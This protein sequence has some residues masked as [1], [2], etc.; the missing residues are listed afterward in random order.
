MACPCKPLPSPDGFLALSFYQPIEDTAPDTQSLG[1]CPAFPLIIQRRH[2]REP[3]NLGANGIRTAVYCGLGALRAFRQGLPDLTARIRRW[4]FRPTEQVCGNPV[5][6]IDQHRSD[7]FECTS[8]LEKRVDDKPDGAAFIAA[9]ARAASILDN[10]CWIPPVGL[11]CMRHGISL[12]GLFRGVEVGDDLI[13]NGV[14]IGKLIE[15]GRNLVAGNGDEALAIAIDLDADA[16]RDCK[17]TMD[18]PVAAGAE[19]SDALTA[20]RNLNITAATLDQPLR[21]VVKDARFRIAAVV[22]VEGYNIAAH[23]GEG[24]AVDA[25]IGVSPHCGVEAAPG[26]GVFAAGM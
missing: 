2:C 1:R 10:I 14:D 13:G 17:F 25:T 11:E 23:Q 20:W 19:D 3:H 5:I 9:E 12:F 26:R 21:P 22:D 24:D 16:V 6:G 18:F 8:L 4:I 7:F 15:R